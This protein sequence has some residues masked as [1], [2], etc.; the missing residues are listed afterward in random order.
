M[1]PLTDI[2]KDTTLNP[3][4]VAKEVSRLLAWEILCSA[5]KGKCGMPV[6]VEDLCDMI[7]ASEDFYSQILYN[8]RHRLNEK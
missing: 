3:Y 8:V 5:S 4:W 7:G 1:E 2:E 6:G